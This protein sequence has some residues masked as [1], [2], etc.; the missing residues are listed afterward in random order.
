MIVVI[1]EQTK[2]QDEA[3]LVN[4]MFYEGLN[5]YHVRKYGI[6]PDELVQ[7]A[8]QI[9]PQFVSKLVF[10]QQ[11]EL[12][13]SMGI[14]R[15]HLSEKDRLIWEESNWKQC[16]PL[17]HYSTSVHTANAFNSL[18]NFMEYAFISPVFD[19]ISKPDYKAVPI[20]L[21]Q[22]QQNT[23]KR[24][25]LG[26]INAANGMKALEMGFDGIAVLGAVWQAESPVNAFKGLKQIK[27]K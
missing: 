4:E 11:F 13:A 10:H 20:D 7:F 21:N 16:N 8:Q 9:E 6:S 12:G 26:G 25:A 14:T 2:R 23:T 5:L 17:L 3:K 1:S 22:Y 15:I 19:S 27:V 24:V 18:P